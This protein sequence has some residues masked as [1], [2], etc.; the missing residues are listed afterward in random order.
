MA[1]RLRATTYSPDAAGRVG[2]SCAD[3]WFRFDVEFP[4]GKGLFARSVVKL[5]G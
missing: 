5:A 1:H 2:S 3:L 4:S